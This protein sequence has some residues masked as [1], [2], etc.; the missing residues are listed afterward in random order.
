MWCHLLLHQELG[1]LGM[2][3]SNGI[4]RLYQARLW[5]TAWFMAIGFTQRSCWLCQARF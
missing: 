3:L 5:C 1:L 2:E 4:F